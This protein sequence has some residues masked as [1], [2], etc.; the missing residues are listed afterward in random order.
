MDKV[1][2]WQSWF[3]GFI[4]VAVLLALGM[5]V[6]RLST[7]LSSGKQVSQSHDVK[8]LQFISGQYGYQFNY[9]SSWLRLSNQ[10]LSKLGE[11]V[12]G[13]LVHRK[14][15]ALITIRV[16]KVNKGTGLDAL[17]EELD[18]QMA[19]KFAGFQKESYQFVTLGK[20]KALRYTYSFNSNNNTRVK[21][22]Q[23]ILVKDDTAF[24]LLFHSLLKD[25][26][27]LQ[28]DWEQIAASFRLK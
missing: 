5:F 9:P 16:A 2:H 14:P 6:G 13:A 21:Q 23:Q 27:G 12:T 7:N 15:A 24:Y 26:A 10:A 4:T 19:K 3:V 8:Q 1:Q 28:A 18:K 17:P 20:D 25:F 22:S 11:G